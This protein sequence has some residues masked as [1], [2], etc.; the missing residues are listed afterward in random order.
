MTNAIYQTARNHIYEWVVVAKG[1]AEWT[2]ADGET[3]GEEFYRQDL[4]P[5]V[6]GDRVRVTGC[7]EDGIEQ[8]ESEQQVLDR[9]IDKAIEQANARWGT[10]TWTQLEFLE[11]VWHKQQYNKNLRN[12]ERP[13]ENS[14]Y[15]VIE[16]RYSRD[17]YAE[18]QAEV[19]QQ[20]DAWFVA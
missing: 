18:Q 16:H 3:C 4:T 12:K 1:Q 9:L 5:F 17:W 7:D 15:P 19:A 14:N 2:S 11:R 6:I 8:T 10:D 13:V 20:L